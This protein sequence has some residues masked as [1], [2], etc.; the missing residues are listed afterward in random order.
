M[1]D[2][3]GAPAASPARPQAEDES[4]GTT[5]EEGPGDEY[6]EASAPVV[7]GGPAPGGLGAAVMAAGGAFEGLSDDKEAEEDSPLAK[8]QAARAEVLGKRR[9]AASA[10]KQRQVEASREE[11]G[12]FLEERKKMVGKNQERN[13]AEEKEYRAELDS[14]MQFGSLWEQV[15]RLVDLTPKAGSTYKRDDLTRMRTL[16]LQLK[17]ERRGAE[18]KS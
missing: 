14:V 1:F 5:D 12:K 9:A 8:W 2:P 16:L 18:K 15:A 13:R 10:E 11:V 7:L 4:G 6:D 17:N 3:F